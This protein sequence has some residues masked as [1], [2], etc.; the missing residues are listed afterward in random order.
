MGSSYSPLL[1]AC[2]YMSTEPQLE[3]G[4]YGWRKNTY[5]HPKFYPNRF[6]PIHQTE[7]PPNFPLYG[8]LCKSYVDT[9][10]KAQYFVIPEHLYFA[11]HLQPGPIIQPVSSQLKISQQNPPTCLHV[12]CCY[13]EN[14]TFPGTCTNLNSIWAEPKLISQHRVLIWHLPF[15]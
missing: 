2:M 5:P 13:V 10:I 6:C 14:N 4:M 7:C 9:I 1:H 15:F 12:A 11:T 3:V 8:R